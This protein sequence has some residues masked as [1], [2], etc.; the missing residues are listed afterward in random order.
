MPLLANFRYSGSFHNYL[1]YVDMPVHLNM[2]VND[3]I[4]L[5]LDVGHLEVSHELLGHMYLLLYI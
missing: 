5:V 1:V 4:E 3:V 2:K